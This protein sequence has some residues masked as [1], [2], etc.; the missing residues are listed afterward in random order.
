MRRAVV[1]GVLAAAGAGLAACADH[2]PPPYAPPPPEPYRV[3][4]RRCF[5]AHPNYDLRAN[6]WWD[7]D[8]A[9]HPC[10]R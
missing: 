5:R 2:P 6:I 3:H 9:P 10:E 8:G 7:A 1:A 4:V